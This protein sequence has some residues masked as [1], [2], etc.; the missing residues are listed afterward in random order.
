MEQADWTEMLRGP[1]PILARRDGGTE[2]PPTIW[3][4]GGDWM[5]DAGFPP[6]LAAASWSQER[7]AKERT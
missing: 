2:R 6:G 7:V 1:R 5:H 4:M 3:G